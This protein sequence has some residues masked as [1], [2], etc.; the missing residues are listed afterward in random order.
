MHKAL[1]VALV[2][3]LTC[4]LCWAEGMGG[5]RRHGKDREGGRDGNREGG[6]RR[7][8]G[9]KDGERRGDWGERETTEHNPK[10][11]G[12]KGELTGLLVARGDSWIEVKADGSDKI[13]R[14][15]PHWRGGMPDAGG[16]PDRDMLD[17]IAVLVTGNRVKL[18][19]SF[20][21]HLRIE[22]VKMIEVKDKKGNDHG[23]ITARG[24]VW[25]EIKSN[26]GGV[27]ERFSVRMVNGGPEN[28]G[29]FDKET[30]Q[31]MSKLKL[32]DKIAV[33]WEYDERKRIS[34]IVKT[35]D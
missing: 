13:K 26:N 5:G 7:D 27:N 6:D 31:Q 9:G 28:G 4:S 24:E 3:M 14:Y 16:G 2:A 17:N 11:E 25:V 32:G 19:W 29:S 23:V 20:E 33:Q 22:N 30:M 1:M 34:K 15:I 21:E 18:S 12:T 35:G 8:W 10:S